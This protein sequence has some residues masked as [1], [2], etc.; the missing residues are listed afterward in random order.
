GRAVAVAFASEGADVVI[1]YLDEKRDAKETVKMVEEKGR[2]AIAIAGEIGS[3]E[4]CKKA[5]AQAVKEFRRIDILVNNAAEQHPQKG[6]EKITA[7]QLE[8]TFR[9]NIFSQ[10]FLTKAALPHMK[11]GSAIINTTSVTA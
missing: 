3:E 7:G 5:I 2:R 11:K 4:F 10:F 8:R 1:L 6:L 9:T